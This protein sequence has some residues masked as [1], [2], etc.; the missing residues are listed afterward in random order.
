MGIKVTKKFRPRKLGF[1]V[2]EVLY[3]L[4]ISTSH[5]PIP[6]PPVLSFPP[7]PGCSPPPSFISLT[8]CFFVRN[9]LREGFPPLTD[10]GGGYG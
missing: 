10:G 9:V 3:Q 5:P 2:W 6:A 1:L 7:P 4:S 8:L